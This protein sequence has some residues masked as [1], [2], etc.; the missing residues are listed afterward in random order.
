MKETFTGGIT[1]LPH[2]A[3]KKE[4]IEPIALQPCYSH[5]GSGTRGVCLTW[6]HV[7]T[8]ESQAPAQAYFISAF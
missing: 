7:R 5:C 3:A 6:G 2:F 1:I 4:P 8:I